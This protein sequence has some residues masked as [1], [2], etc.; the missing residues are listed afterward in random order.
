MQAAPRLPRVGPTLGYTP[1]KDEGGL[2]VRRFSLMTYNVLTLLDPG[3][4]GKNQRLVGMRLTAK[5]DLLK[6]QLLHHSV[7]LCGLQETRLISTEV[8]PD[9]DFVMLHAAA[10]DGGH[11][12]VALWV[13]DQ[14][15]GQAHHCPDL[16]AAPTVDRPRCSCSVGAA[17]ASWDCATLLGHM[18]DS[19]K[20]TAPRLRN[21]RPH[22][23]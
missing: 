1:D 22:R 15:F 13:G 14:F 2:L 17:S 23:C 12:G 16:R 20:P 6:E 19:T 9:K 10:D 4:P 7:L 11:H 21:H 8:L 5:R 3:P 18:Q